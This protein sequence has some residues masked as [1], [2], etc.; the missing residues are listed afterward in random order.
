MLRPRYHLI[1]RFFFHLAFAAFFASALRS[2]AVILANR[3]A[4]IWDA[5]EEVKAALVTLAMAVE[6]HKTLP[7]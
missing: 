4:A 2:P 3:R 5:A 7:A 6:Y 1:T